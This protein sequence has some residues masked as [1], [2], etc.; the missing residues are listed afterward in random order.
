MIIWAKISPT[1]WA[2]VIGNLIMG[3]V[4]MLGSHLLV[5]EEKNKF[6]WDK[7]ALKDLVNFGRWIMLATAMTFLATQTDKLM[8]GKL[9]PLDFLGVYTVAYTFADLP[10][11]V[12]NQVNSKVMF[13]VISQQIH[14]PRA[15]LKEKILEKRWLLLLAI[16]LGLTFLICFGDWIILILYDQRYHAGA[17]ILP[18]L[19]AGLWVA[20]LAMTIDPV[21]YALGKP[22]YIAFGNFGKF[23]YMLLLLPLSYHLAGV[24]GV[25][26]VI[27]ANDLPFYIAVL[28]GVCQENLN[29]I[30]QDL[31]ATSLLLAL[32][33]LFLI[34]R[35]SLGGGLPISLLWQN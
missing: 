12:M 26:I 11:Q 16:L 9:F 23:I 2:L 4:K 30:K 3:C 20:V 21:L 25:I 33:S 7:T 19:A 34:G 28:Y 6:A 8:L 5:P 17:W 1:I 31:Q 29:P 13:P 10:R 32:V 24:F 22:K 18:I 14:L 15:V 27:A 35:W